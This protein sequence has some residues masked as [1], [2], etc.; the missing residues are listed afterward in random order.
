MCRSASEAS[1]AISSNVASIS[2]SSFGGTALSTAALFNY[3]AGILT[4]T[5]AAANMSDNNNLHN[6]DEKST[7]DNTNGEA[8]N[9][10]AINNSSNNASADLSNNNLFAKKVMVVCVVGGLSYLEIAAFRF[11]SKDPAF[12]F[13]IVMATTKVVSG[14]TFL[15]SMHHNF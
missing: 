14:S 5:T 12:P 2:N 10:G 6:S 13:R 11:L 4:S 9:S 7:V 15:S 1:N 3:T 8:E